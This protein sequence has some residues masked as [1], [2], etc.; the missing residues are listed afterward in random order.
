[1]SRLVK[2]YFN[3]SFKQVASFFSE[4]KS[5]NPSEVDEVIQILEEI[6][7]KKK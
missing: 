3:N 4:N 1:M 5:L 6:K 2:E 7:S